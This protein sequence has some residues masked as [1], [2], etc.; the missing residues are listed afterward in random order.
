MGAGNSQNKQY[1]YHI[2]GHKSFE[3]HKA[4]EEREGR[5][6][7]RKGRGVKGGEREWERYI[8]I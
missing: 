2:K 4:R 5:G 7:R 8:Y 1:A 6:E 3:R